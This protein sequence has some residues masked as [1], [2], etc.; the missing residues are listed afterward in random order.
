MNKTCQ[1]MAGAVLEKRG[2]VLRFIGDA[3]L[4]IFPIDEAAQNDS[5]NCKLTRATCETA[6]AAACDARAPTAPPTCCSSRWTW[7]L[8]AS[9]LPRH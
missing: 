4:A 3:V 5:A 2:E 6:L 1:R 7:S 8:S 9:C